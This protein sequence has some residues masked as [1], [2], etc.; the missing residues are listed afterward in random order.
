VVAE[1][2][3][4]QLSLIRMQLALA[5]H[6]MR[7]QCHRTLTGRLL[8][9][10]QRQ[11]GADHATGPQKQQQRTAV[12]TG[13]AGHNLG[14]VS[15]GVACSARGGSPAVL[16]CSKGG[17]HSDAG[18]SGVLPLLTTIVLVAICEVTQ[19]AYACHHDT[20]TVRTDSLGWLDSMQQP[21]VYLVGGY[22][23]PSA[24]GL[25]VAACL[26]QQLHAVAHPVLAVLGSLN[27]DA[28]GAPWACSLAV[29][30]TSGMPCQVRPVLCACHHHL[31]CCG[32][33][34]ARGR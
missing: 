10:Q 29:Y 15:R 22:R 18:L 4:V 14:S 27:T 34:G 3:H 25:Q 1:H 20:S 16:R 23:E 19:T 31:R 33:R 17:A 9:Q 30:C 6:A 12:G 7:C 21:Q 28:L 32:V 24:V 26:L 5:P 2:Y 8:N 11:Y 13:V